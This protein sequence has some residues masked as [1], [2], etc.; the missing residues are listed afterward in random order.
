[1]ILYP[2]ES[3]DNTVLYALEAAH[4]MITPSLWVWM[5][6]PCGCACVVL[7]CVSMDI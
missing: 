6:G 1:V 2:A 5:D 7:C 3:E 4:R